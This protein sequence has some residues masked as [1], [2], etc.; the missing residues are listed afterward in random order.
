[1]PNIQL[2]KSGQTAAYHWDFGDGT[3]LHTMTPAVYHDFSSSLNHLVEHQNFD[4]SVKTAAGHFT[5]TLTITNLYAHLKRTRNQL[6]PIVTEHGFAKRGKDRF[7]ALMMVTNPEKEPITLTQRRFTSILTSGQA[8]PGPVETLKTPISIK[9]GGM[10]GVPVWPSLSQVPHDSVG[11]S[12]HYSGTGPA[13][14]AVRLHAHF[15]LEPQQR[16]NVGKT[17][18]LSLPSWLGFDKIIKETLAKANASGMTFSELQKSNPAIQAILATQRSQLSNEHHTAV[19][20]PHPHP[21]AQPTGSSKAAAPPPPAPVVGAECDPENLPG[22]VPPG[23]VCQA[24]SDNHVI[25]T[26]GRFTNARKGDVVLSPG[27]NGLIG[28]LLTQV[29]HPQLYSHSGIMTRNYDEI[30]HCIAVA[31]RMQAYPVGSMLGKTEPTE[32]LRPDIVEYGW[33]GTVT[34]T[35]ENTVHGEPF[36]DPETGVAYNVQGFDAAAQGATVAGKWHITPPMVVKPDPMFET[37]ELRAKLHA[38]ADDAADHKGKFSYR[39]FSYTDPNIMK[40]L[41]PAAAKWA[42]STQP[43]CCSSFIWAMMKQNGMHIVTSGDT[44]KQSGLSKAAVDAGA[45]VGSSTPDGLFFYNAAER[46]RAAEWLHEQI[47]NEAMDTMNQQIKKYLGP[48]SS[49]ASSLLEWVTKIAAHCSNEVL[50]SFA[51]DITRL[52]DDDGGWEN[53]KDANAVSPDNIMSWNGQNAASPG[54]CKRS[55]LTPE[56]HGFLI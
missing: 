2:P 53:T 51:R 48:L 34:Q 29:D 4:V 56:I 44:A 20:R 22:S 26:Q 30:T 25:I 45:R 5:R 10:H 31:D 17:A 52:N 8:K 43:G 23:M 41:A 1:M 49:V 18:V 12:V 21:H 11:F 7:Y 38:V 37:E 55:F 16:P 3:K 24:T 36:K 19:H 9:P 27:G 28:E 42:T 33:P 13:K 32:G 35:V 46:K 47:Y 39:L 50:N 40:T 15:D 14:E 54:P 6:H